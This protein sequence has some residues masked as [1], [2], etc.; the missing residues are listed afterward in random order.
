[1]DLQLLC[2]IFNPF[3]QIQYFK[4]YFDFVTKLP[5]NVNKSALFKLNFWIISVFTININLLYLFFQ[6]NLTEIDN[7]IHA[8]IYYILMAKPRINFFSALVGFMQLHFIL[9]LFFKIDKKL[10]KFFIEIIYNNNNEY[11]LFHN[12]KSKPVCLYIQKKFLLVVNVFQTFTLNTGK[13]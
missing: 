13:N 4:Q 6:K 9:I 12:Y 11:F 8:N 2:F 10:L 5:K 1:M 7:I 3:K